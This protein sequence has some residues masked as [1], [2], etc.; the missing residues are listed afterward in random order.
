MHAKAWIRML[1]DEQIR[2]L[3]PV[4][5]SFFARPT[6]TVARDLLG[7]VLATGQGDD[8]CAGCIVETEAYLGAHD[9]G[10]HAATK[11]VTVRNR[12]MY[13]PPGHAYVYFT[14]GNHHML[15]IVTEPE[16]TAGAVLV[17]A[18]EPIHGLECMEIRRGK[19]GLE[20]TNGPGKVA[21]AF[22]I[23]LRHNATRLGD[24]IS[25]LDAERVPDAQIARSGRVG[26]SAGYDLPLR[27][28][29]VG[30]PFVSRSR[31]GPRLP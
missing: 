16:G 25:I 14:Y 3:Q 4:E 20:L 1:S 10:S 7:K 23:D 6:E 17:R 19:R 21:Q 31:P 5:L 11:G 15:N 26:L 2:C 28:Y 8:L 9:P 30:N 27:F 24:M 22:A 29:I 18:V 12:V 13:G